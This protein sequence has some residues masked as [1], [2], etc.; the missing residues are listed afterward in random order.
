VHVAD[1]SC[2]IAILT[3]AARMQWIF[4]QLEGHV[5][6]MDEKFSNTEARIGMVMPSSSASSLYASSALFIAHLFCCT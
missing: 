4:L 5:S 2:T 1:I 6:T 3:A